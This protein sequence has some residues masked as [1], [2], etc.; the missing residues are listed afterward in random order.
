[1]FPVGTRIVERHNNLIGKH[2]C[3]VCTLYGIERQ[4]SE[5]EGRKCV[6]GQSVRTRA[7]VGWKFYTLTS[8]TFLDTGESYMAT[9]TELARGKRK[10]R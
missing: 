3:E 5:F 2:Q 8:V 1:M 7:K 9:S 10:A 4:V 6:V